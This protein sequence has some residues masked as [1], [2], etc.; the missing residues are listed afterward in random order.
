MEKKDAK[1]RLIRW[2]LLLQEFDLEIHDK[3][4]CENVVADH[5]SRITL[6]GVDDPIEINEK[7]LD[8]QLL[9]VSTSTWYAHYVNYLATGVIPEFWS[10]KRRQQFMAQVKKYIWD[11]PDLFEVGVDKVLRRCVP[12]IEV[13]EIL[14]HAHSSACGGHFSGSKTGY[15]VEEVATRTNDH[16]VVCKFVQSNIFS[17]FRI[18]RIIV[19][20]GGSHFKNFAFGKLLKCYGVNH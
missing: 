19:S 7:F 8:E 2:V 15:K 13:Q 16:S 11:E 5:L 14:K 4:R 3:L 9:V 17:R 12:E 18:P 1:P 10:K 6:E 20:D